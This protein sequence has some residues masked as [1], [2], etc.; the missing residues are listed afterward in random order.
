MKRGIFF[1]FLAA[2][3]L[4]AVISIY[5]FVRLHQRPGLPLEWGKSAILQL[6]NLHLTS[7]KDREFFLSQKNIGSRIHVVYVEKGLKKEAD[8]SLV[9]FYADTPFQ[10]IYLFIGLIC[11]LIGAAV[12]VIRPGELNVRIF[13][14]AVLVFSAATIISHGFFFD[15]RQWTSFLPGILFYL[16][17]PFA[18]VLLLHFILIQFRADLRRR[19]IV[20]Y[21]PAFLFGVS[22]VSLFLYAA[23]NSSIVHFRYYQ[24]VYLAFRYY[25][26]GYLVASIALLIS[27]FRKATKAEERAQ[28]KWIFLGLLVGLVPFILFYQLPQL[29]GRTPL[30]S[31]ELSIVFMVFIPITFAFSIVR[32][33][34]MDIELI[35]NRS[36]V[37]SFLTIFTVS[38]YLFSVRIFQDFIARFFPLREAVAAA[39]AALA[40]AAAFHPARRRIQHFVDK[41]FFRVAYDYRESIR[42]FNEKSHRTADTI[43]LVEYFQAQLHKTMP[44]EH[45]GILVYMKKGSTNHVLLE[46]NQGKD[47]RFLARDILELNRFLARRKGLQTEDS[48]DFSQEKTLEKFGVEVVLPIPFRTPARTGFISLGKKLSGAKF[49]HEDL[50]LLMGFAEG[51]ALNLERITL[52]EEVILERTEKEKLDELNRMKTEFVT[53]VSHELRT[54][55]GSLQGLSEMLQDGKIKNKSVQGKMLHLIAEECSRL[56]RFLHNILDAGRIEQQV[57]TYKK[58][59]LEIQPL[60]E[61]T[62]QLFHS[63]LASGR[64]H[65]H[66]EIPRVPLSLEVDKDAVKQALTNLLDNAIKYSRDKREISVRLVEE[67]ETIL[68]K[69]QDKGIGISETD[70]GKIFSN[71]FRSAEAIVHCPR[72][73]GLG[74]KVVAHIMASHNGT[75]RVESQPG[76]GSTFTLVFPRP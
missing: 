38:L 8:I 64:F 12:F 45:V 32:F 21:L 41:S 43:Q 30:L 57:K 56:T 29:I 72:G 49:S 44:V 16:L 70:Q 65:L 55:M 10:M 47:L 69:V 20:L 67:P 17:Y 62:L 4:V 14:L 74:L 53:A 25:M 23:I 61:D 24:T 31:E 35:I 34:L 75:V 3:T 27:G 66:K 1:A 76:E 15:L 58:E 36:L 60:V 68:I 52:Q 7:Q 22:L 50:E 46:R 71:F 37:Y 19:T 13:Y 28:L 40:A 9:P 26:V 18:P 39:L 54:P 51:L 73:V 2:G 42:S 6:D 48:A 59:I 5:G 63:Q 11:L 33:R